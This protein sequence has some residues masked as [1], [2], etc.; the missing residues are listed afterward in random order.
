[1]CTV[2]S[3]IKNLFIDSP[4]RNKSIGNGFYYNNHINGKLTNDNKTHCIT[5]S[6][7]NVAMKIS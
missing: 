3:D 2:L 7:C 6:A 4:A 5:I 1:M